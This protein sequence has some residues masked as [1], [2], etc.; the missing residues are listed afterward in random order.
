[1]PVTAN[2]AAIFQ[3]SIQRFPKKLQGVSIENNQVKLV[4]KGSCHFQVRV[5]LFMTLF[6]SL[7]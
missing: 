1:M 3:D 5:I 2:I 4:S 6:F 7:P